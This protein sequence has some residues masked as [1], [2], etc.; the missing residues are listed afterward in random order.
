MT[1][2]VVLREIVMSVYKSTPNIFLPI[3]KKIVANLYEQKQYRDIL[4][5]ILVQRR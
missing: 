4:E 3:K 2:V 1:D 5:T